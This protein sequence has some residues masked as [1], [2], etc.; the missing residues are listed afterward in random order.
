M[1][2][3]DLRIVVRGAGLEGREHELRGGERYVIGRAPE[4]EIVVDVPFVSRRQAELI[5][6]D[7]GW[8]LRQLGQSQPTLVEGRP[9][10]ELAVGAGSR[11]L[12]ESGGD[13]VE[14][15][16]VAVSTGVEELPTQFVGAPTAP[17]ADAEFVLRVEAPSGVAEHALALGS[18][19]TIGRRAD[20]DILIEVPFVSR[21]QAELVAA[22]GGWLLRQVGQ[23]NP[24]LRDGEAVTETPLA[25]G[26]RFEIRGSESERVSFELVAEGAAAGDLAAE[27]SPVAG[28]PAVAAGA[29]V[30]ASIVEASEAVGLEVTP[31]EVSISAGAQAVFSVLVE[32][33]SRAAQSWRVTVEGLPPRWWTLDFEQSGRAFPGERREGTLAVAVPPDAPAG[34]T[35]FRLSAWAGSE[36]TTAEGLVVVAGRVSEGGA[37]APGVSMSSSEIVVAPGST[38]AVTVGVR[39]VGGREREYALSLQGPPASW[40]TL[41]ERLLIPAGRAVDAE[42][43]VHP[44]ANAATGTQSFTLRVED[45]LSPSAA[46]E[47]AGQLTVGAAEAGVAP[48]GGG[49]RRRPGVAAGSVAPPE[50]ALDPGSSFA[51]DRS[52]VSHQATLRVRNGSGLLERYEVSVSGV[53]AT[54][55]TLP[56]SE[57]LVEGGQSADVPLRLH[58]VPDAEHPA[59]E[60]EMRIRVAPAADPSAVAEVGAVLTIAGVASYEADIDPLQAR[61]RQATFALT[62]RNTGTV[63]TAPRIREQLDPGG[64][65]RLAFEPPGRLAPGEAE[66]VSV[67]ASAKRNGWVGAS[68]SLDF[69]LRVAPEGGDAASERTVSAKFVHQPLMTLPLAIV[70]GVLAVLATVGLIFLVAGLIVGFGRL[71]CELQRDCAASLEVRNLPVPPG[72]EEPVPLTIGFQTIEAG[73]ERTWSFDL[74]HQGYE[75]L[76]IEALAIEPPDGPYRL[77]PGSDC[78]N[79]ELGRDGLGACQLQVVFAPVEAGSTPGQL[80]VTHSGQDSPLRIT[81]EGEALEPEQ[82]PRLQFDADSLDFDAV[83]PGGES[84][85]TLTIENAGGGALEIEGVRIVPRGTPFA[86]ADTSCA[87]AQLTV[88]PCTATVRFAPQGPEDHSAEANLEVLAVGEETPLLVVALRGTTPPA[89]GLDVLGHDNFALQRAQKTGRILFEVETPAQQQSATVRVANEGGGE[90]SF[91]VALVGFG[92]DFQVSASGCAGAVLEAAGPACQFEVVYQPATETSAEA[93]QELVLTFTPED[94]FVVTLSGRC[95]G[96]AATSTSEDDASAADADD[97]G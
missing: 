8:T 57:A 59:A 20:C 92:Q 73:D 75:A 38:E 97:E 95:S 29:S 54:W 14:F 64:L 61:G 88:E 31:G 76:R 94:S 10:T 51:F 52:Q 27:G 33:R 23:G 70:A 16:L 35:R 46:E 96:C 39:N 26:A 30:R 32:N 72:A 18:G 15:E 43:L 3:P 90:L 36:Q 12:V 44:P 67:L 9:L 5:S 93:E 2:A 40:F 71:G 42:L 4:C 19:Y 89:A 28:S 63:T 87:E 83:E 34:R 84:T 77:G 1:A 60:Y 7:D 91:D 50:L 69:Q 48:S 58:P 24:V 55:Y 41:G 65:A 6:S 13:R 74:R 17:A 79:A 81:L 49:V 45:V 37:P 86:I 82:P 66:R 80:V 62:V 47:R 78:A 21:V 56:V 53:P 22:S 85:Q 11:F 68:K 25:P